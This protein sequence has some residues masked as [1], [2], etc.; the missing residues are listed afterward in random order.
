MKCILPASCTND[1]PTLYVNDAYELCPTTFFFWLPFA[2]I[3]K[4]L[5]PSVFFFGSTRLIAMRNSSDTAWHT[6]HFTLSDS[7]SNCNLFDVRTLR[8]NFKFAFEE[9][10]KI[11]LISYWKFHKLCAIPYYQLL[12]LRLLGCDRRHGEYGDRCDEWSS[13]DEIHVGIVFSVRC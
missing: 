12:L 1:Q 9:F 8:G 13:A 2:S 11:F 3:L 6:R 4:E 5:N 10:R 7:K